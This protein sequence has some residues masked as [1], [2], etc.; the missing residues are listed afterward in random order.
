M[1]TNKITIDLKKLAEYDLA[2]ENSEITKLDRVQFYHTLLTFLELNGLT[3]KNINS[4]IKEICELILRSKNGIE[5]KLKWLNI[6]MIINEKNI[7]FIKPIYKEL[8]EKKTVDYD[9]NNNKKTHISWHELQ[10]KLS[11]Y[12]DD[13]LLKL[14]LK[15]PPLRDDWKSVIIDRKNNQ[16]IFREYK[17]HSKYDDIKIDIPSI[18]SHHLDEI[19]GLKHYKS[20]LGLLLKRRYGYNINDFRHAFACYLYHNKSLFNLEEFNTMMNIMGHNN[21]MNDKYTGNNESK[22]S[23]VHRLPEEEFKDKLKINNLKISDIDKII[24]KIITN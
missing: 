11:K 3:T 22:Q 20:K 9:K 23:K 17:T 1:N 12:D 21:S 14:Y 10:D 5:T 8:L 6:L 4:K 16:F 7:D 13:I 15:F 24:R 19:E 18:L 2:K